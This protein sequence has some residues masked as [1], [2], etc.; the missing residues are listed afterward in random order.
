MDRMVA[1]RLRW[2]LEKNNILNKH[3]SVF[4]ERRRP[5]DHL[6]RLHDTVYKALANS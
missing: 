1:T 2:Y 3:Q 4:R 6:L 5:T